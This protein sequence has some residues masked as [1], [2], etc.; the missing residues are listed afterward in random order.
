M[1]NLLHLKPEELP[2]VLQSIYESIKEDMSIAQNLRQTLDVEQAIGYCDLNKTSI[3][4]FFV[5]SG[6]FKLISTD[7]YF[8]PANLINP[9]RVQELKELLRCEDSNPATA[10][11]AFRRLNRHLNSIPLEEGKKICQD[12]YQ[13]GVYAIRRAVVEEK[14]L[15]WLP[16]TVK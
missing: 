1:L 16:T 13:A 5:W 12:L 10:F 9:T 8:W 6:I 7:Q 3:N 4:A 11:L 15:F 2:I 14:Q